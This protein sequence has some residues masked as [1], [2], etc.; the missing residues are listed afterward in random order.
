MF[1]A[2][3]CAL[4]VLL[5][6]P[7]DVSTAIVSRRSIENEE[8]FDDNSQT[9]KRM[10]TTFFIIL[11]VLGGV[12]MVV[13]EAYYRDGSS[14]H[15]ASLPSSPH[16]SLLPPSGHFTFLSKIFASLK[17]IALQSLAGL[18]LF[19]ILFGVL[20]GQGVVD[21]SGD[22]V[23][24]TIV[25]I[26]NTTGLFIL[27]LLLG[28]GL[29]SFP[30]MLWGRGDLK[31]QLN[32]AQQKAASRFKDLS[33]I[34]LNMSMAVSNVMKTQQD[35]SSLDLSFLT[36]LTVSP[37]CCYLPI[38][39]CR[40]LSVALSLSLSL[41]LS[42]SQLKSSASCSPELSR[43][44]QIC[45]EECPAEFT[46]ARLGKV[47]IDKKAGKVTLESLA[48]LRGEV[49]SLKG[50]FKMCQGKVEEAKRNAYY[51][52]D[53]L[54]AMATKPSSG[55]ERV[56][57]WSLA[58]PST[59]W[60]YNWHV[61][62]KPLLFRLLALLAAILSVFSYLGI[63]GTMNGVGPGVSVYFLAIHNDSSSASG[64]CVF[65]LATLCHAIFTIIWS[66]FQMKIS[67][68]MELLPG[69]TTPSSLSVNARVC[70]N[71]SSPLAF[72]Y[73]G[74]IYENGLR[75]GSWTEGADGGS[76][77]EGSKNKIFTAF[78]KFYQ[79]DIIPVMSEASLFVSLSL[80]LCLSLCLS[81]SLS[82]SLC[83]SLSL[84]L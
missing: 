9:L 51:Y 21:A 75:T 54:E 65:V 33:E 24:L 84:S 71:L 37:C 23:L 58:P 64:I 83:L 44:I 79:I 42:R 82:V 49:I 53:V 48:A 68:L 19:F 12:V 59:P 22:A 63:I 14:T 77:G 47:A 70:A 56:I 11:Q 52:E 67:N 81:L 41:S 30:Q 26:S 61:T 2:Y 6:L 66:V 32:V 28:Y 5:I 18:V 36:S 8:D 34:S 25:V 31:R 17:A 80:A 45:V 46:S 15:P 69:Q 38:S 76:V 4:G 1:L 74:W 72:F 62:Y 7:L 50:S 13:Q 73:L 10:Y 57:K 55:D 29:I 35:V 40:S 20:V 3:F 43:A 60:E 39:L 78:S 16:P 27:M